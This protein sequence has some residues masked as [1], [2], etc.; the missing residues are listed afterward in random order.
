MTADEWMRQVRAWASSHPQRDHVVDDSRDTI[1]E[2]EGMATNWDR[3]HELLDIRARRALT[4]GE[5]QEYGD[6]ARIAQQLDVEE[7]RAA[8]AAMDGLAKGHE[9]VIASIR[10]ATAALNA[11]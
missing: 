5:Q 11:S 2:D 3:W 7:G 1:Y 6:Y 10:R 8:D 9:R 4:T